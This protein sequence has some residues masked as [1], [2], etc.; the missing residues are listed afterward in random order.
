[1]I[2]MQDEPITRP[3]RGGGREPGGARELLRV[4]WPLVLSNSFLTLQLTLARVLLS[5]VGTPELAASLSAAMIFWTPMTLLQFT[6]NYATTF[7]AQYTGAGQP[8]RV[9]PAV[10]QALHL[11]GAGGVAFLAFVP[12]TDSLIALAGHEPGLQALEATYFRVLCVAALPTLV[13]AAASSFFTGLGRSG[14][15][16]LID[17]VGLALNVVLAY[18]WIS[19]HWGFAALGIAGAGWATVCG[20]TATAVLALAL[21]LRPE[22]R[23]RY[24]TASGWRLEGPLLR[25]LLRFGVPNG[26]VVALETLAFALFA[27]FVG[28]LGTVAAAATTIAFTLNLLVYMPVLGLGQA[29]GVLVGQRL[30]EDRPDLAER[31]TWTGLRVALLLTT[32]AVALYLLAPAPLVELFE[33]EAHGDDG[34]A[35]AALAPVLLRFVAIYALFDST[36]VVF[37]FALRGAGDTRFVSAASLAISWGVLV[38]PVW[39]ACTRGGGLYWAWGFASAYSVVLTFALLLRFRQGTWKDLRVL[40]PNLVLDSEPME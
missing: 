29:V 31:T 21:M 22:N 36:N 35:V 40:E 23:A 2:G 28:R 32:A 14:T 20:S 38:V 7:V 9:G 4:A 6:V 5:R 26:F 24:A 30:G 3:E 13:A 34:E 8:Q 16:L 11:A 10:W 1:M 19:G 27:L 12:V 37:S 33:S 18:G 17:A 25:R 39:L 15:I